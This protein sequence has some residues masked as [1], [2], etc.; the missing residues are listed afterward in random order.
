[1]WSRFRAARIV[2][3]VV[4]T[5]APR[6]RVIVLV[7]TFRRKVARFAN[8]CQSTLCLPEIGKAFFK[9]L[10]VNFSALVQSCI[11]N[12]GGGWNCEQLGDSKLLGGE[13]AWYAVA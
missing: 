7:E 9:F 4:A 6:G 8:S 10:A 12:G 5:Q 1:M 3:G 11:L 13:G 2:G